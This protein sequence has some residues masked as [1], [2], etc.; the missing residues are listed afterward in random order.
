M[1]LLRPSQLIL[2]WIRCTVDAHQREAFDRAQRAWS[3]LNEVEGFLV[4][5][6]GW[7]PRREFEAGILALWCDLEHY[8]AFMDQVHDRVVTSSGQDQ[9][10]TRIQTCLLSLRASESARG[11]ELSKALTRAHTIRVTPLRT[12]TIQVSLLQADTKRDDFIA[13]PEAPGTS[14]LAEMISSDSLLRVETAWR[15]RSAD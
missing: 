4:Q 12:D 5:S 1:S 9:T 2:K 15:V 13:G 8:R 3:A 6:G 14:S 7:D 10:Y 11:S